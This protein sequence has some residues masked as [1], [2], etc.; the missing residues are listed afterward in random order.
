MNRL[1]MGG[2]RQKKNEKKNINSENECSKTNNKKLKQKRCPS[3]NVGSI[4]SLE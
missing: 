2:I 1:V 4:T 3:V